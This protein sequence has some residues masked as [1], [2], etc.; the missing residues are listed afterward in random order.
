[1]FLLALITILC[2]GVVL[3]LN[4]SGDSDNQGVRSTAT[5]NLG[6]TSIDVIAVLI[7]KLTFV[8]HHS[9]C[10]L[11]CFFQR[12]W[13]YGLMLSVLLWY[14]SQLIIL[15][16]H[17]DWQKWFV[18]EK[19]RKMCTILCSIDHNCF[20]LASYYQFTSTSSIARSRSNSLV[21][22]HSFFNLWSSWF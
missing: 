2:C 15:F 16:G 3:P 22:K 10:C 17:F 11:F 7:S 12:I 6:S 4:L 20:F 1:M 9:I 13:N 18:F 21:E 8:V 14:Q 19:K 5:S